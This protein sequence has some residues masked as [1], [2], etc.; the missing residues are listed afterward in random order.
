MLLPFFI[1]TYSH[2]I[3]NTTISNTSMVKQQGKCSQFVNYI[4]G[5][6]LFPNNIRNL[7]PF[8]KKDSQIPYPIIQDSALSWK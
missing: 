4:F 6:I 7:L 8:I 5:F 1:S 3:L 2:K